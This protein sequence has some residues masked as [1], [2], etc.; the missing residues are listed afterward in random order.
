MIS[1]GLLAGAMLQGGL[2][3]STAFLATALAAGTALFAWGIMYPHQT[4]NR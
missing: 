4:R 3:V 2:P 1:G